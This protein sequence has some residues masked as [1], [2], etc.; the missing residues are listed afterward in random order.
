MWIGC[1]DRYW[2][3]NIND[4]ILIDDNEKRQSLETYVKPSNDS[5]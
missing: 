3:I 1:E 5:L 4:M 2:E